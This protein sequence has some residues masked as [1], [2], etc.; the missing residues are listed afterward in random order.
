MNRELF[1]HICFGLLALFPLSIFALNAARDPFN[2]DLHLTRIPGKS[3]KTMICLH[4]M[5]ADYQIV[6]FVKEAS[7]IHQS[8]VS[9]N[10][11]DY[12]MHERIYDPQKTA[13]GSIDEI[14]P[15]IYVL[16]KIIIEEGNQD[17][18][19]YGFS[20]GGGAIINT[21]AVL[22][23]STYD[24][25]LKKIGVNQAAKQKILDV[26]QKGDVILDSP[27]KSMSE[28]I[29]KLGPSKE[30]KVI[31]E[32]FRRNQME[33]ID[34]LPQLSNLALN[35]IIFFQH[36][37]EILSNRDDALFIER[38]KKANQKGKTVVLGGNDGGHNYPHYTL[39]K[40]YLKKK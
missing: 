10:F 28:I 7:K 11:P 33:P 20:A 14:L 36:P 37:D 40:H 21:L 22:N 35:V 13:F 31:E 24:A 5:G 9:F 19:L 29:A 17:V 12:R 6:Y 8:L 39:W 23:S 15:V 38:L 3:T 30:L 34:V 4:G 25:D 18:N 2:Y 27:L 32:R 1:I 16:N 26:I